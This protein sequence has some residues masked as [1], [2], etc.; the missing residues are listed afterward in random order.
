MK[1]FFLTL[2]LLFAFS[3]NA[4]AEN[5]NRIPNDLTV[6]PLRIFFAVL[7]VIGFIVVEYYFNKIREERVATRPERYQ[8]KMAKIKAKKRRKNK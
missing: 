8:K 1:K 7:A 2:I 3:I 5:E 6:T 4:F